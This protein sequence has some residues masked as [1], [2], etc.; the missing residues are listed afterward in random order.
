MYFAEFFYDLINILIKIAGSMKSRGIRRNIQ[1]KRIEH[2]KERVWNVLEIPRV[3]RILTFGVAS[4]LFV[5]LKI[6]I[7][8]FFCEKLK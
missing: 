3:V 5:T 6:N 7:F 1:K 4:N 8:V 2:Q